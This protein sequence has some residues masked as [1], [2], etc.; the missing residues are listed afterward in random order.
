MQVQAVAGAVAGAGGCRCIFQI[1]DYFADY[2]AF[3]VQM[4]VMMLD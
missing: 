3:N 1:L 4:R 2:A